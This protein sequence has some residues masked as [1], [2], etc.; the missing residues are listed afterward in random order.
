MDMERAR[1]IA[2]LMAE[3]L[4]ELLLRECFPLRALKKDQVKTATTVVV[5]T[6]FSVLVQKSALSDESVAAVLLREKFQDAVEQT[7]VPIDRS[8]LHHLGKRAVDHGDF[9]STGELKTLAVEGGTVLFSRQAWES[10]SNE[11]TFQEMW[12]PVVAHQKVLEG[13]LGVAAGMRIVTDG[14]RFETL[15][16]MPPGEFYILDTPENLGDVSFGTVDVVVDE[17]A[18]DFKFKFSFSLS[19]NLKP[20]AKVRNLEV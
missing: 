17:T 7:L 16:V 5:D 11:P 14:F 19:F 20:G 2:D 15:Q 1:V 8:F 6:T 18:D 3:E 9:A 13:D 4:S 10:L 12:M